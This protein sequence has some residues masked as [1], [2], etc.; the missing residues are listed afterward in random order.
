MRFRINAPKARLR[1][2]STRYGALSGMTVEDDLLLRHR[3]A[4]PF[5]ERRRF[6]RNDAERPH[7]AAPF[8][9][10]APAP[11]TA[12]AAAETQKAPSF[13]T[14]LGDVRF[15]TSVKRS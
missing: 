10:A 4:S 14:G 5:E 11:S 9:S 12:T 2:S 15:S 8:R 3:P 6:A 1:A 7:I 13:L